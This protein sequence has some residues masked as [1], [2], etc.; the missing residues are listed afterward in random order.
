MADM[1][2]RTVR[3]SALPRIMRCPASAAPSNV[4]SY[5]PE[6]AMGTLVH[7]A[8]S[9][10]GEIG[11]IVTRAA[12]AGLDGDEARFLIYAA[13]E[14]DATLIVEAGV[15]DVQRE[16]P[17]EA[18]L[19]TV[20]LTGT[21]DVRGMIEPRRRLIVDY[22]A[23]RVDRD[24]A[25]QL[26]GYALLEMLNDKTIDEVVCRIAWLRAGVVDT[27]AVT[28]VDAMRWLA[29]LIRRLDSGAYTDDIEVCGFCPHRSEC[30]QYA[31]ML[32][33]ATV[34]LAKPGA[35]LPTSPVDLA[36][37]YP[38]AQELART[39]DAYKAAL[40]AAV[41]QTGPIAIGEGR[42]VALE[43]RK[44]ASI[45]AARAA[46]II[47]AHLDADVLTVMEVKKSALE[48]ALREQSPR[49]QKKKAV[50]DCMFALEAAGALTWAASDALVMR[51][52]KESG[53]G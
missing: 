41:V 27:F 23:G 47:H 37:L 43:T 21:P 24:Y 22:K 35:K 5:S 44:R 12:N 7:E 29:D 49:G 33:A 2:Q 10:P 31:R 20:K 9:K 26:R 51:K 16:T 34:A 11:N 46:S 38:A 52:A 53:N 25:H 1:E 32:N 30:G 8:M 48:D 50:E 4:V 28:M 13:L 17:L 45:D 14:A 15:T 3:C 39:L 42:E 18:D 40:R 6:A 36:K 19:A